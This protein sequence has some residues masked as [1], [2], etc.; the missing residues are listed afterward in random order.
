MAKPP[1]KQWTSLDRSECNRL[2]NLVNEELL[3][4]GSSWEKI[5]DHLLKLREGGL[6][7]IDFPNWAAFCEAKFGKSVRQINRAIAKHTLALPKPKGGVDGKSATPDTEG[8]SDDSDTPPITAAMGHD[9]PS[10]PQ[11]GGLE[12]G[13]DSTE[14]D[15]PEKPTVEELMKASNSALESLARKIT[16]MHDE[17]EALKQP[18]LEK[19]GRLE[20]LLGQLRAAAGTVRASKG[21]GPCPYCKGSGCKTCYKTGW[22]TKSVIDS[23]PE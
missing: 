7:L 15:K 16:A 13:D 11:E 5:Q 22:A 23:A 8:T 1:A 4:M 18:H 17:A 14:E 6:Y 10:E 19:S 20:I 21:S 2:C 9:V 12:S 3:K